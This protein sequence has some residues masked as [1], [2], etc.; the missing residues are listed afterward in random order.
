MPKFSLRRFLVSMAIVAV[1]LSIFAYA[2]R[3]G[4]QTEMGPVVCLWLV[5]GTVAGAG[6][7][8]TF[9]L[10]WLGAVLGFAAALLAGLI[11]AYTPG[12]D[13]YIY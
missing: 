8:N 2:L 7:M 10:W 6:V 4:W 11:V 13:G 3:I 1:G 9:R 5:G 12:P